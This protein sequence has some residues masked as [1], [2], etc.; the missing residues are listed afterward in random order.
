VR[1][2]ARRADTDTLRDLLARLDADT[3]ALDD[4]GAAH[5]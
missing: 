4:F 1:I 2:A 5:R 3:R